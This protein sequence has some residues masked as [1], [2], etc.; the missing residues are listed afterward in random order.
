MSGTQVLVKDGTYRN[1][2]FGSGS[3]DNKAVF[4]V[5]DHPYMTSFLR[6]KVDVVVKD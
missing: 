5:R 4:N 6:R 1:E 2:G 3:N